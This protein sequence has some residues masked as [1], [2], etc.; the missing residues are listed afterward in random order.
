MLLIAY[1]K[2]S[3]RLC[4]SEATGATTSEEAWGHL[5]RRLSAATPATHGALLVEKADVDALL[6]GVGV[7]EGGG[8]GLLKIV[9]G[10]LTLD[11][12]KATAAQDRIAK[13]EAKKAAK[14]DTK[15][16]ALKTMTAKDWGDLTA[17]QKWDHVFAFMK[18]TLPDE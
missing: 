10:A 1:R 13:R 6:S 18:A 9:D 14:A 12:E 2:D 3:G 4:F 7:E 8:L 17:A 5:V 11:Q 15:L 16:A